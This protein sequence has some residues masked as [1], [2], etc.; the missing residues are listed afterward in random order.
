MV[1]GY[2]ARKLNDPIFTIQAHQ[3]ACPNLAFSPY[4]P[5]MMATS[6]LD[7]SVKVWDI[8]ANGGSKPEEVGSRQM[9]QGELFSMSFCNDIPWVLACGGSTGEIAVWDTSE[10]KEIEDRF[11]PTLAKGTYDEADYDINAEHKSADANSD[12]EDMSDEDVKK[13]TLSRKKL[14]AAKQKPEMM[15]K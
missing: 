8:T 9:K 10:S 14:R 5:N 4:I 15:K 2:D 1:F 12:F 6:S 3:K 7:G 11:R 13:P